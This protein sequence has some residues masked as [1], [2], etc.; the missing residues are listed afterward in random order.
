MLRIFILLIWLLVLFI[1]KQSLESLQVEDRQT[2]V[3]YMIYFNF[4]LNQLL[5][6]PMLLINKY[7]NWGFVY[8]SIV[9]AGLSLLVLNAWWFGIATV[10]ISLLIS[11]PVLIIEN[12]VHSR[13]FGEQRCHSLWLLLIFHGV[14]VLPLFSVV[15]EFIGLDWNK[16]V[17]ASIWGSV[18]IWRA[19]CTIHRV[20]PRA[21]PIT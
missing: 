3:E 7:R 5:L 16:S 2:A 18:T 15:S 11:I 12:W 17:D 14:F 4:A 20:S 21:S 6:I 10:F 1:G 13:L 19:V 9:N 8:Y